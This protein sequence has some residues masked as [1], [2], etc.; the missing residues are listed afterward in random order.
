MRGKVDSTPDLERKAGLWRRTGRERESEKRDKRECEQARGSGES[1]S[2]K[3]E[4][5]GEKKNQNPNFLCGP[6]EPAVAY[7]MNI[8]LSACARLPCCLTG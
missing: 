1:E 6:F 8:R 2:K 7:K 3:E 4:E 5:E